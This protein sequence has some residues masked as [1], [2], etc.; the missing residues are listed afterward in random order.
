MLDSHLK[1]QLT[2]SRLRWRE[3][4]TTP[5]WREWLTR[6]ARNAYR[7]RAPEFSSVRIHSLPGYNWEV[8]RDAQGAP[9]L[10]A[11]DE[12]T[13]TLAELHL[14]STATATPDA[15]YDRSILM[16]ADAFR[17][18]GDFRRYAACLG[19]AS[20]RVREIH[21]LRSAAFAR[22]SSSADAM[23]VLMHEMA[24][25]VLASDV[26]NSM[27]WRDLCRSQIERLKSSLTDGELNNKVLADGIQLGLSAAEA[28]AQMDLYLGH[29]RGNDELLE[30]LSCDLL[31]VLA[32]L[33]LNS[34]T[35]VLADLDAGP[36]GMST[37]SVGDA[38]YVAQG[39]IQNLQSTVAVQSIVA[40][41]HR[42]PSAPKMVPDRTSS[43][44]TA[45]STVLVSFITS[46]LQRWVESGNLRSEWPHRVP[47]VGGALVQAIQRRNQFRTANLLNPI[48][49]L[50]T[51]FHDAEQ[52]A[53]F[54]KEGLDKLAQAE[55]A[56]SGNT[57][58]LDALRWAMTMVDD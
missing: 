42:A 16:F 33:N 2:V 53:G 39:A 50:D 47:N 57:K 56:W 58:K 27:P 4:T 12:L 14:L 3:R 7:G 6:A 46:L 21:A 41:V 8:L 25:Q 49:D 38:L 23:M 19:W 32:F 34:P 18:C 28:R 5:E 36:T 43:E 15:G 51:L 17:A 11:D 31:G 37:K 54:E 48:E 29:L 20:G 1:A 10:V 52:Y 45:R 40:S 55:V 24:H 35:D 30:E 9:C 26:E 44:L 13:A 22:S